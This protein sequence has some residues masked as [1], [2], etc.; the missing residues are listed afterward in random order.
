MSAAEETTDRGGDI[1]DIGAGEPDR[2]QRLWT[3]RTTGLSE[4]IDW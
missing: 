2:L 4:R 1:V 3:P